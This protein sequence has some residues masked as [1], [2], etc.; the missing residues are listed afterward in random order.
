MLRTYPS[1]CLVL[2]YRFGGYGDKKLKAL[3]PR[4]LLLLLALAGRKFKT[5]P[6][7]AYWQELAEDLGVK[8]NT[9]RKWAYELRDYGLIT[10]KQHRGRDPETN[11][12]GIRNER[13]SFSLEPFVQAL[14][15]AHARCQQERA[16]RGGGA[17][18]E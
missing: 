9:V 4:H 15:A 11:R 2:F 6:I 18:D 16:K 1:S 10:I 14:R 7:R 13:N 3:Q 12:S 8:V 17:E 5:K